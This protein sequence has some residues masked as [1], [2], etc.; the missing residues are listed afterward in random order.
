MVVRWVNLGPVFGNTAECVCVTACVRAC[1]RAHSYVA[2]YILHPRMHRSLTIFCAHACACVF[3]R[4]RIRAIKCELFPIGVDRVRFGSQA[5]TS[6]SAFNVDI[7]AWNTARVTT[8]YQVCA[9]LGLR[10]ATTAGQRRD[11]SVSR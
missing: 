5:F 8:L 9:A 7:G 2:I 1:A 10:R 11:A 4:T 6:A 3:I